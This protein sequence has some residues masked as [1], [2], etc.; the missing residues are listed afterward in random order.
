MIINHICVCYCVNLLSVATNCE[1]QVAVAGVRDWRQRVGAIC[2]GVSEYESTRGSRSVGM[3]KISHWDSCCV[4]ITEAIL[5][6][7]DGE[8]FV[9]VCV[10]QQKLFNTKLFNHDVMF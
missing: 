10:R 1:G 5:E 2:V 6:L 4:L 3:W 9:W 7:E 8:V